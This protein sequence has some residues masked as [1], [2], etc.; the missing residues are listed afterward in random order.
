[1]RHFRPLLTSYV[2]QRCHLSM[3]L[4][5]HGTKV[6]TAMVMMKM[7][8]TTRRVT[9]MKMSK[10]L[11]R[12]GLPKKAKKLTKTMKAKMLEQFSLSD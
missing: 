3:R 5:N 10:L 7:K 12:M 9:P 2:N 1:M 6:D 11:M 8:A 4:L